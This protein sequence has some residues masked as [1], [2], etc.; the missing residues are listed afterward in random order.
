MAVCLGKLQLKSF[1]S[2]IRYSFLGS[3]EFK[4]SLLAFEGLFL[5]LPYVSFFFL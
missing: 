1:I 2:I 3:L 5:S 4:F